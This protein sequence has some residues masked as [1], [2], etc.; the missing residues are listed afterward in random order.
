[1]F[2]FNRNLLIFRNIQQIGHDG[3]DRILVLFGTGHVGVLKW[4]IESSAEYDLVEF[5]GL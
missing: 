4:L 5:G 2:W 1:M 3:D